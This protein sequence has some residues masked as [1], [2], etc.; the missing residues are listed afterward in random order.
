MYAWTITKDH[1]A[2]FSKPRGTNSNAEGM[3]VNVGNAKFTHNEIL[4]MTDKEYF[5]M[6]D[7]DDEL[8]YEG[9]IIGDYDGFE[10]LDDFGQP[11]AGAT[12]IKY[13]NNSGELAPI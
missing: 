11:N 9:Y 10:P 1:I 8:Y 4:S 12:T 7:D 3:V 2:D 5:Q 6:T 13:L